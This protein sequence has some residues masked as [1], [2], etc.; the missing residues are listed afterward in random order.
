[1]VFYRKREREIRKESEGS[2]GRPYVLPGIIACA[3]FGTQPALGHRTNLRVTLIFDVCSST[4]RDDSHPF[5]NLALILDLSS[6]HTY[7]SIL[8]AFRKAAAVVVA[9]FIFTTT[10]TS[11][12]Y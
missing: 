7:I 11:T 1:M 12:S 9:C 6:P 3:G 5:P 10:T 4:I 2:T 8:L